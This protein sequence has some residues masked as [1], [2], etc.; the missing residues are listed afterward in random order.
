LIKAIQLDSLVYLE[1]GVSAVGL[2]PMSLSMPYAH[3]ANALHFDYSGYT[4]LCFYDWLHETTPAGL[5]RNRKGIERFLEMLALSW[6]DLHQ[7][8]AEQVNLVS[9]QT[10]RRNISHLR[11]VVELPQ[12]FS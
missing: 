11:L 7:Q 5:A 1:F 4:P 8:T 9:H 10:A 12:I 2:V 6:F 3:M